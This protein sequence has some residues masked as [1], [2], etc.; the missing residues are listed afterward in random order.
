[1]TLSQY[2]NK[3][4]TLRFIIV[5]F[6]IVAFLIANLSFVYGAKMATERLIDLGLQMV[7]I[8]FNDRMVELFK[9]NPS[10]FLGY[11][12]DKLAFQDLN[13]SNPFSNHPQASE[14][15]EQCIVREHNE[16][17]CRN[18]MITKYGDASQDGFME[19]FGGLRIDIS[20]INLS[21]LQ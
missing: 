12:D 4:Y 6:I 7:D 21:N 19:D 18:A 1:M 2:L 5:L 8:K 3:K 15:Y 17:W 20:Q 9:A 11:L 10:I 13:L 16:T 14:R